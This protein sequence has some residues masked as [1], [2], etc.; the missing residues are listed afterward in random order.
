MQGRHSHAHVVLR[1]RTQTEVT[2][3]RGRKPVRERRGEAE[4]GKLLQNTKLLNV[5]GRTEVLCFSLGMSPISDF[6]INNF[7]LNISMFP[8]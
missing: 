3:R 4:H 5:R 6:S 8:T 7:I 1:F 2:T